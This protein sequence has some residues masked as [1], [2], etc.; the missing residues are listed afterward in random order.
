[1]CFVSFARVCGNNGL[2][3]KTR[4]GLSVVVWRGTAKAG[5]REAKDLHV[6]AAVHHTQRGTKTRHASQDVQSN[7]KIRM[8]Y[9]ARLTGHTSQYQRKTK[10]AHDDSAT[11]KLQEDQNIRADIS[12][13]RHHDRGY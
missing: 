3:E 11:A 2:E 10:S 12:L 9:C 8:Q 1:M 7:L 5:W 6:K 4:C 13:H